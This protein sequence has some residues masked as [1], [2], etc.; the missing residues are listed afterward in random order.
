MYDCSS[1]FEHFFSNKIFMSQQDKQAVIS[2]KDLNCDFLRHG[3]AKLR[4]NHSDVPF[5]QEI[6]EQG[7]QVMHTMIRDASQE[8]DI[9]VAVVFNKNGINVT[10]DRLKKIVRDALNLSNR[11]FNIP[12]QIRKNAV[13]VW[14]N[15][16]Y[17]IDF[18]IYRRSLDSMGK[19]Y[20]E[21]LGETWSSRDPRQFTK[22]FNNQVSLRSPAFSSHVDENQLRRI[23]MFF[24]YFCR[25]RSGWS[26]PGGIVLTTLATKFY[27]PDN[28]RD[29]V[30]FYRTIEQIYRHLMKSSDN[31]IVYN[32]AENYRPQPLITSE[33]HIK[34]MQR[35]KEKLDE[36]FPKLSILNSAICTEKQAINA[37]NVFFNNT[38]VSD[39]QLTEHLSATTNENSPYR[40]IASIGKETEDVIYEN[41]VPSNSKK[42]PRGLSIRFELRAPYV[43]G[44]KITWIVDNTGDEAAMAGSLH[45]S[46]ANNSRIFWRHLE[47][48]GK[49]KL[50]CQISRVGFRTV[51]LKYIVNIA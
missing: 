48:K 39:N 49:H 31:L 36:F 16:G 20:Y 5:I 30:S 47:Y 1:E 42:Y 12:P 8:Y 10:D 37:W 24:K 38:F 34:Q 14:Y 22:W 13:T 50:T 33:K 6:F 25:S 27:V 26:L 4:E 2:A 18:A 21:H 32:E 29:D 17:H 28:F 3:I 41:N 9:D 35:L 44:E 15:A 45:Y 23:V 19:P 43:G 51:E 7:S 40:L 46:V 11:N